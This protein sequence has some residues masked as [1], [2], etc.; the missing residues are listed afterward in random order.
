MQSRG[1]HRDKLRLSV[2][3]PT[4]LGIDLLLGCTRWPALRIGGIRR[5]R[6]R[7]RHDDLP[8]GRPQAR[9]RRGRKEEKKDSAGV[10]EGR[11]GEHERR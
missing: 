9:T 5:L 11:R 1:R 4:Q 8:A 6:T 7:R 2:P 3:E 10:A